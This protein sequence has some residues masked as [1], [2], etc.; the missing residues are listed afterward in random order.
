M[1]K[2]RGRAHSAAATAASW[3][4]ALLL[5]GSAFLAMGRPDLVMAGQFFTSGRPSYASTHAAVQVTVWFL[6][7]V[8]VIAQLV[9]ATRGSA[10]VAGEMRRRW[11]RPRLALAVGVLVLLGGVIHQQSDTATLCCGD[12]AR[13]DRVLR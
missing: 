4:V 3:G 12:V 9:A 5:S 8:L 1:T 6:V 13:A 2:T 10:R 11:V 7:L